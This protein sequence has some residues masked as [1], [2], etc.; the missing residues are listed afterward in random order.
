MRGINYLAVVA[1]AVAAFVASSAWYA[2]FGKATME[3]SGVGPAAAA[4]MANPAWTAL[5]VVAQS[6]VVAFMLS[7]F[8]ARL[9]IAGLKGRR[10]C[11][12]LGLDLPHHDPSGLRRSR[13][14]AMDACHHPCRGLARKATAHGRHP[15]RLA[16]KT[17]RGERK[18]VKRSWT[19]ETRDAQG[20]ARRPALVPG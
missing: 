5:F 8:V 17:K 9:G 12:R 4:N 18:Q 14:C 1:A 3:L 20:L 15:R 7:Y 6:L 16:W 2:V 10:A 19:R 13:A 11:R